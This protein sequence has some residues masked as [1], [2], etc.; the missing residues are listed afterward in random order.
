[1]ENFRPVSVANFRAYWKA[2]RNAI[3][4][5]YTMKRRE[6]KYSSCICFCCFAFFPSSSVK[7]YAYLVHDIFKTSLTKDITNV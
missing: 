3:I 6:F 5:L 2:L 1:M 4:V 7:L